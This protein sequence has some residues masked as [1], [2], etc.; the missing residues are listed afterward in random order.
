VLILQGRGLAERVRLGR[1]LLKRPVDDADDLAALRVAEL[2]D[3]ADRLQRDL[4]ASPRSRAGI[5]ESVSRRRPDP[6][7]HRKSGG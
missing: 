6:T 1:R 3:L 7:N 5:S 2:R 4:I